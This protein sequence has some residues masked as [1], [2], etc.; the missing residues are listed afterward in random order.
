[1]SKI[2]RMSW[3]RKAGFLPLGGVESL[4]DVIGDG[5][6]SKDD[7]IYHFIFIFD[8]PTTRLKRIYSLISVFF[9]LFHKK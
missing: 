8:P 1:M 9:S 2:Y 3:I 6:T 4:D 7:S 5:G